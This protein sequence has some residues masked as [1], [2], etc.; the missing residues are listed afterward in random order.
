MEP[1]QLISEKTVN[2]SVA[3]GEHMIDLPHCMGTHLV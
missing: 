1:D 3:E 2:L